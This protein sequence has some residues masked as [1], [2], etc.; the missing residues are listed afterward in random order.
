[1]SCRSAITATITVRSKLLE[2]AKQWLFQVTPPGFAEL[3][4]QY[5]I[6]AFGAL[7]GTT[8]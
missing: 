6:V 5:N 3:E 1:M 4:A 7:I 8:L 2:N